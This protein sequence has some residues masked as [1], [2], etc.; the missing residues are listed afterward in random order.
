[1]PARPVDRP[2]GRLKADTVLVDN[3]AGARRAVEHLIARGH[4]PTAILGGNNRCTI[5]ALHALKGHRPQT[6]LIGFDDF[7]LA[8]LL[9]MTVVRTDP[10]AIGSGE[11]QA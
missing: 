9:A 1:V 8:D 7:A 2:A 4:L 11:V 3:A 6:A 5:G 10:Y